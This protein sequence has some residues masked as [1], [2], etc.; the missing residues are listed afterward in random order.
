VFTALPGTVHA[1]H[2]ATQ[3]ADIKLG[4][5]RVTEDLDTDKRDAED[6]PIVPDVPICFPRGGGFSVVFPIAVGDGVLV[7][8]LAQSHAEFRE[9]GQTSTPRDMRRLHLA[10]SVAIPFEMRVARELSQMPNESAVCIG[11]D[12][13]DAQIQV[14]AT[15]IKLGDAS[16]DYIALAKKIE[17]MFNFLVTAHNTHKHGGPVADV[18]FTQGSG[19]GGIT[20]ES[21]F[22]ATLVKAK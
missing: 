15:D 8:C 19:V 3:T 17:T 2:A 1:Y 11:T 18:L 7:V 13:A 4:V 21:D 16:T 22:A 5:K 20:T 6:Y 9:T 12:G 14:S 10:H